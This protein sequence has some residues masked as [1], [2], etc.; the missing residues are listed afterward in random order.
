MVTSTT[1]IDNGSLMT[2]ATTVIG[3]PTTGNQL[4]SRD[5]FPYRRYQRPAR[6][7]LTGD[8]RNHFLSRNRS[9][10]YAPAKQPIDGGA[11]DVADASD[12]DQ[13]HR[14]VSAHEEK[15]DKEGLRLHWQDG[16][17]GECSE[18]QARIGRDITHL[19]RTCHGPSMMVAF[20]FQ[21][22]E[23]QPF[24]FRAIRQQ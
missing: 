23:R 10:P 24:V 13:P 22:F 21:H 9:M 6:S 11:E 3:S 12:S 4:P 18:K 19:S 17:C 20:R 7:S 1:N 2:P 15:P 14:R 8:T 5:H 16:R